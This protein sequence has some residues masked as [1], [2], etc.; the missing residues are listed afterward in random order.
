MFTFVYILLCAALVGTFNSSSNKEG[1]EKKKYLVFNLTF[2]Y[3]ETAFDL[4][5][6]KIFSFYNQFSMILCVYAI[7]IINPLRKNKFVYF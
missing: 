6:F 4:G 1:K 2:D 7:N 5:S 3:K